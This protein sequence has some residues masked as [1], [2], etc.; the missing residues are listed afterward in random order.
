[1]SADVIVFPDQQELINE[2]DKLRTELSM[3]V[4]EYDELRFVECRNIEATYMLAVG[5]LEYK[6]YE[7][8]CLYLRLKRKIELI[9]TKINRQEKVL[10]AQI[11]IALDEEFASYKEKLKEK[12]EEMNAAIARSK[13]TFL[14][15]AE[16]TELKKLYR[17]I[18][19]AIHPDMHPDLNKAQIELFN[20]A[21]D[22]YA[23]GDLNTIRIID[24]MV[25]EPLATEIAK[26]SVKLRNDKERL[27]ELIKVIKEWI[28]KCKSE[29]PYTVK[30][31]VTDPEKMAARKAEIQ[32]HLRKYEDMIASYNV[33]IKEMM[34]VT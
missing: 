30:E 13:G 26:N 7:A 12:M 17:R 32:E 21:V 1:L 5:S 28:A 10:P 24:Q 22:A 34:K 11:E 8:E 18:V 23:N 19:K 15:E 31:F 33:R 16:T 25:A 27:D 29:Y 3:L 14:S 2:V 9:Q 6:A 20:N 4:L